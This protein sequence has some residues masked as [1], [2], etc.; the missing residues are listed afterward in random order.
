MIA[1]LGIP[2][3]SI[4]ARKLLPDQ[5][6]LFFFL[7]LGIVQSPDFFINALKLLLELFDHGLL[8]RLVG[9]DAQKPGSQ[10][11]LADVDLLCHGVIAPQLGFDGS[12]GIEHLYDR[13][14]AV[15]YLA[16]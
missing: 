12:P 16:V 1:Y 10:L 14:F 3:F 7:L 8:L 9:F 13:I 5:H 4:L 15:F 6:Q 11:R 2:E